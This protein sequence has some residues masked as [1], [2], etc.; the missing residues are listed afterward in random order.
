MG[1]RSVREQTGAPF[2]EK[3]HSLGLCDLEGV[4][5]VVRHPTAHM[6][7]LI[8]KHDASDAQGGADTSE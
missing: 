6:H 1:D 4:Y 3:G 2:D 8:S 7:G 5:D